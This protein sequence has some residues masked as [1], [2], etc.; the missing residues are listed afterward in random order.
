MVYNISCKNLIDAELLHITFD[1]VNVFIRVFDETRCLVLFGL[2]KYDVIYNKIRYLI[3]QKAALHIL[4]TIIKKESKL[5][6]MI[7]CL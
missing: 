2:E 1:K 4:S 5:I 3:T 7:L 6:H